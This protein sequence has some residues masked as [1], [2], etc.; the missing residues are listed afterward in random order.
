M[1]LIDRIDWAHDHVPRV[2]P[3]YCI[4]WEDPADPDAPVVIT[5]PA[6]EWLAMAMHGGLLPPIE[7]YHHMPLRLTLADG[8]VI[9]TIELEAQEYRRRAEVRHEAV[10]PHHR[11]HTAP[12]VGPLSER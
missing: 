8:R 10:L 1:R 2:E 5:H 11:L 9:E 12:P 7:A 3:T 6:P 4:A